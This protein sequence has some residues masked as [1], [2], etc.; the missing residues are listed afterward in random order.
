M[1]NKKRLEAD[2]EKNRKKAKHFDENG[3][4]DTLYHQNV[5]RLEKALARYRKPKKEPKEEQ[6]E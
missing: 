6:E 1:P 3:Q 2:L 5:K 4:H